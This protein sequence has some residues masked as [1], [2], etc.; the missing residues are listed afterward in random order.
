MDSYVSMPSG[1]SISYLVGLMG[2]GGGGLAL[3]TGGKLSEVTVVVTLPKVGETWSDLHISNLKRGV[4][5]TSTE[6]KTYIL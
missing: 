6:P 3:L 4:G 5:G 2:S 1:W